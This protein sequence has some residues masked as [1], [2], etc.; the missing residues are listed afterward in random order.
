MTNGDGTGGISIYGDM[1]EDENFDLH[2]YGSGWVS[3]ANA[4]EGTSKT[5]EPKIFS[6][7]ILKY[8]R[9]KQLTILH[10]GW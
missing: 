9:H 3:M 5:Y 8:F 10:H 2:H 1:F 4:G 7:Q 6:Y